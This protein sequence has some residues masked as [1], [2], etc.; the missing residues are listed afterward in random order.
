MFAAG[1]LT[2]FAIPSSGK[3]VVTAKSP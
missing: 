3:M 1:P 2:G